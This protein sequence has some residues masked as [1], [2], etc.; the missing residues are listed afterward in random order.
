MRLVNPLSVQDLGPISCIVDTGPDTG[1][2]LRMFR[3]IRLTNQKIEFYN[4]TNQKIL[5]AFAA[6]S[7][8]QYTIMDSV[9]RTCAH[10]VI[11]YVT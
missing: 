11:A 6:P 4:L 5:M 10:F 2:T 8:P 7:G 1:L 3:R 9:K